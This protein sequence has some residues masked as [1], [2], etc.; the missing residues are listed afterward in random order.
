MK[1]QTFK[2]RKK[3]IL[4]KK[5]KSSKKSWDKKIVPLCNKINQRKEFYTTSS[6]SGRIMIM[7]N[8]ER[9]GHN[10][11]LFTSHEKIKP[12]DILPK[13]ENYAK[14]HKEVKF[15]T[16]ACIL[17]VSCENVNDAEKLYQKAKKA[18]WKRTGLISFKKRLVLELNSTEKI[19][20]PVIINHEKIVTEDFLKKI[21]REANKKLEKSWEKITRLEKEISNF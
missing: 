20:F 15:K 10:L 14:N 17:H 6:C 1:Q 7:I 11:F 5:D 21:V 3:D 9:K 8:Q 13:L 19:E 16:E 4:S 2:Q 18:G 12:K